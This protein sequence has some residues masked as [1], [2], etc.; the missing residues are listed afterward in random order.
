V[1]SQT[2]RQ[3]S[4]TEPFGPNRNEILVA[5]NPYSTWKSGK[6]KADLVR[7]ISERLRARVPGVTFSF[8]QPIIDMVTEAV[9]GSSADLAVILSG[10]DLQVLRR[11][12]S[13]SLDVLEKVPG[14]ADVAI[15]QEGEQPQVRIQVDRREAA[16]YGINVEDIQEVIE[17]AVGGHAVSTFYE[18]ER[19]FD[20]TVRYVPEA[21]STLP[22]IGN[23]VIATADSGR[24]PLARVARIEIANGASIIARRENRRQVSV[25]TN[26][27]GRDQGSF[28]AQ[29]QRSFRQVVRLASGYR[30]EWGG[31]FENLERARKR[32][33]WI[34]P[35]TVVI[36]FVL[37]YWTF[38]SVWSAGLVLATVPFSAIG[39]IAALYIRG[40]PF[41]VSAAVG[42]VSL[43]GV[44]VMSGVIYLSETHRL[45]RAGDLP[46][47]EAILAGAGTQLR[48]LLTLLVLALLGMVPAAF[49]SGIGS[50]IQ[51]PLA[52]VVLGGLV[53]TLVLNLLALPNMYYLVE[54]AVA[55]RRKSD[56][57]L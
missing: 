53:S 7:E 37:L 46:I 1:T 9:T 45:K 38:H 12:A 25:R 52:T 19:R 44:A 51:R 6:R 47:K 3:D 55:S 39:G 23:I 57:S 34:L 22:E 17:L 21:R 33:T 2:G 48:P 31:T 4:N 8:T 26:I 50:D 32:L 30:V 54:R 16:R 42:F 35:I 28:V 56:P 24:I 13:Q 5:L 11:L 40:I 14:S 36:I 18:A 49:A 15:E 20:I 27:R 10:P 29:A 43:F 41:S